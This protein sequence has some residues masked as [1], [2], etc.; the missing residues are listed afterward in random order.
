MKKKTPA[1]EQLRLIMQD[2]RF[3]AQDIAEFDEDIATNMSAQITAAESWIDE[4]EKGYKDGAKKSSG[5]RV[6]SEKRKAA[7]RAN[8]KK[9]SKALSKDERRERAKKAAAARW[10][11]PTE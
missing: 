6:K 11:R 10:K 9:A 7:A 1:Y 2:L 8:L 3:T 5:P 4:I